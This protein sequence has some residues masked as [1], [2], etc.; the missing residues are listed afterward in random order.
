[1]RETLAAL[2]AKHPGGSLYAVFEP[3]SATACRSL[4]QHA[5]AESFDAATCVLFPPLGRQDIS[6]AERLDL[7]LLVKALVDRGI[8]ASR[9]PSIEAIVEI[10]SRDTHEGDT[11]ALLS[12]GAFGGIYDKLR[13]TLQ[14]RDF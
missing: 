6:E 4:H 12:N 10:L 1:V 2:R 9:Q 13:A 11:I 3:R 7:D 8:R 5:Y 14:D